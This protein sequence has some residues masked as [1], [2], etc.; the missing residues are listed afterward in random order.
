MKKLFAFI[1]VSLIAAAAMFADVSAKKLD[2]GNVEVTFFYGN[3]RANEVLLAGD[4]TSW[5]DGALPMTKTDKGFTLTKTFS[6]KDELRY[7]FISDGNWTTD[8]RAPDFVDDGFGGK[9]GH[10]VVADMVSSGGGDEA[11]TAKAKINFVSWTMF[12]LQ[13]QYRTG[14]VT[15]PKSKGLDL[16]NVTLGAKSYDKFT[17]MFLPNAPFYIELA[18]AERELDP[19]QNGGDLYLYR[20]DD[21]GNEVVKF[22][23]GLKDFASGIFAHPVSYLAGTTDNSAGGAGPG[24]NP[25]LGHLKFGF[26][27]PYVNWYT[28]FNYAKPDTNKKILWTTIDGSN[29]DAGYTHVGGFAAFSLGEKLQN[30]GPAKINFTFAPNKSADRKGTK[31]GLWS[32]VDLEVAGV[33]AEVQYNS[34]YLGDHLFVKPFEHDIIFGAKGAVGPVTLAGQML[35]NVYENL[36]SVPNGIF[37]DMMALS[38]YSRSA[39]KLTDSF[40]FTKHTAGE[41][42][43]GYEMPNK[44]LSVTVD[45][46]FRG[47]E[48]NMLYVADHHADDGKDAQTSQL[49][50]LNTQ[51]ITLNA[52]VKPIEALSINIK[53]YMDIPFTTTDY[54]DYATFYNSNKV[55]N[56]RW[57]FKA[58]DEKI[59]VGF[60]KADYDLSDAIGMKSDVSAYGKIKYRTEGKYGATDDHFIFSNAGLK[61][62]MSELSDVLQGVD[63]YYGFNNSGDQ[64]FNTLVA[65][66]GFTDD[67]KADVSLGLRSKTA[68]KKDVNNPFGFGVGVSKKF[69]AM[70]KPIVYAQFVYDMDPY[71]NF[72]DGQ[73]Q[74][75]LDNYEIGSK[76]MQKGS[77]SPSQ[78]AVEV[79]QGTAALRVGVRWDI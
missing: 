66:L 51:R 41:F 20:K 15:D 45:Y 49:G 67:W 56:G 7:K 29:W 10:V 68:T 35:F 50:K 53:P 61:F 1:S 27:T 6:P 58:K 17:G 28:G 34:F 3:P 46:R 44:L 9:N 39:V 71:K 43:V 63:V 69:K 30:I 24:T 64:M 65:S 32:F 47:M 25:F 5:Q 73:D 12:G 22:Q 2:D 37:W 19:V 31:Y 76:S 54:D 21:F 36:D 79:Y 23:D 52:T 38:G 18:L 70:K 78:D 4:F 16:T 8:L 48:A 62:S 26:N 14:K 72:G 11:G 33:T 42:K 57:A 75:N 77:D 59:F 74:L 40:D 60:L 55:D 13:S